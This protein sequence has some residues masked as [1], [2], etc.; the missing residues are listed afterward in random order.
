MKIL[1]LIVEA[2]P[3]K[4]PEDDPSYGQYSNAKKSYDI[5][6]KLFK[7]RLKGTKRTNS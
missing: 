3:K 1:K 2:I 7:Q 5:E 4:R 6:K